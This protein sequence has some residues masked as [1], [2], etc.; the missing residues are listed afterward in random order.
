MAPQAKGKL[1]QK[2]LE[3]SHAWGLPVQCLFWRKVAGPSDLILY[4]LFCRAEGCGGLFFV[5]RCCYRGQAYC[6]QR[7]R[8]KARRE[9]RR[10]AN[11]KH[12]LSWEGRLDHRDR[13]S[14]YRRRRAARLV[15]DQGSDGRDRVTMLAVEA[16][17]ESHLASREAWHDG[18]GRPFCIV[19][20]RS[21]RF[22]DASPR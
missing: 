6:S 2:R 5:C 1:Q 20:G 17:E 3:A 11:R 22:I 16:E 15:T 7:C 4:Q 9:Q 13:Q 14:A 18:L 21:G 10:R 12:Q 8:A 19:C